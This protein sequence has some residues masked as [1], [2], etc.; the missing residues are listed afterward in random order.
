MRNALSA[1]CPFR[2]FYLYSQLR[3]AVCCRNKEINRRCVTNSRRSMKATCLKT[4]SYVMH[5][6]G[7]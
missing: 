7:A 3:G 4:E 2:S 1:Q 6:R 5:A